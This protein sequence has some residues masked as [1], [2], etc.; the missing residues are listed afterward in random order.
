V[1]RQPDHKNAMLKSDVLD[2]NGANNAA[3]KP[4][5]LAAKH[6]LSSRHF[7]SGWNELIYQ[8]NAEELSTALGY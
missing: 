6:Y 2:L 4:C 3:S 8:S 1:G 7:Q 5:E